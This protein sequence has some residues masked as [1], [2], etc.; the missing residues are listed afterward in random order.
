MTTNTTAPGGAFEA[1]DLVATSK[2]WGVL[3]TFGILTAGLG[4][5]II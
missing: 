3:L 4:D 2:H 1:P 5:F